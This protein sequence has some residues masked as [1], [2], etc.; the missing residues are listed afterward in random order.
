MMSHQA[1]GSDW[2]QKWPE[3]F[4]YELVHQGISA[5]LMAERWSLGRED[6]DGFAYESHLRAMRAIQSGFFE[7]QILPV[8]RPDG[9]QVAVD[10]GVR[11]PPDRERMAA[12]KPV[13]KPQ[14]VVTAG[15]ASQISDGAA[16]LVLA[17]EKRRLSAD[18]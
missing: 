12:L 10:E 6:L 2:P 9:L 16:A 13:F 18:R 5:E 15:N 14:G 3:D 11:M 7:S 1:L 17:L 8:T 4:P